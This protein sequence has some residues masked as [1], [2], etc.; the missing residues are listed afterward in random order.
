MDPVAP[1]SLADI[2]AAHAR[3][4]GFA[5]RTPLLRLETPASD[6]DAPRIWLKAENLQPIGSF[7]I[8]GAS[9][10]LAV[11]DPEAL[12]SGVY[13]AS[14]GNM[15]QGVALAARRRGI[16]CRVIVPDSAP[17]TK[18]A[19]IERL[20]G[21]VVPMPYA[22]W[23]SVLERHGHPDEQGLF[24]HPVSDPAVIAGNGTVGLEIL[25]DLPDVDV[26]IAPYG[27]G[28]LSSGIAC[29]VKRLKPATRVVASEVE[30]A[31]P[32]IA[33][34]EA[35]HPVT[36]ERTATFVD[37]IGSG[38]VLEEMWP[39]TSRL[40]DGALTVSVEEIRAAIRLLVARAHLIAE[41]A[42]ASSVAAALAHG[43]PGEKIVAVVS[44][45][46]IDTDVLRE[47]LASTP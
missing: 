30:T 27:G 34:L 20:G 47:I 11:A 40:L 5:V 8:R 38:G 16:T 18:V 10:A 33:S 46:N 2:E 35:G 44:G 36:I 7:K 4:A 24:V 17:R 9:N 42:G 37:G 39:L 14:A 15:A 43:R 32:F 13:T 6:T 3:I 26:V 25:Q 21:V 28:G 1:P 19:A 29:A 12:S 22:E 41:G 45:G 31:A 23:W